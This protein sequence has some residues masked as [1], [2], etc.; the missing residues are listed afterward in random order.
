MTTNPFAAAVPRL[1]TERLLLRAYHADDFDAFAENNADAESM[2][3]LSVKDRET[4]WRIFGSQ[5]G[6][7]MLHGAGW[8]SMALRDT[9]QVVGVIGAFYR[10]QSTAMEIGWNTYRAFWGKGYASE[11][12]A[13]MVA[14]VF[15]VLGVPHVHA[16]I[17]SGNAS[18]IKVAER[19]GLAYSGEIDFLGKM[20]GK[21]VRE[22]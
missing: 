8:W 9:G 11:A 19:L 5:A 17:A 22:R 12:G 10:D 18:S 16:L 1:Q 14:H 2:A 6:L 20:I 7:W 15:D 4:S 3:H 21:Y 13:A